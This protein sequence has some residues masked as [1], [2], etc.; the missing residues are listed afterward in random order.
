MPTLD[1]IAKIYHCIPAS[2]ASSERA[3][4]KLKLTVTDL[5]NRLNAETT[6]TLISYQSLLKTDFGENGDL[7][8]KTAK[9]RKRGS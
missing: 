6:E 3:F 4:S 7:G 1:A 9:K 2:S 8:P 5:R